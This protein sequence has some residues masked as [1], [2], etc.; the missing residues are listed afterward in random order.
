MYF[1]SISLAQIKENNFVPIADFAEV[2]WQIVD[3]PVKKYYTLS[4]KKRFHLGSV[5]E[6]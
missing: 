4:V 2:T 1:E 3:V 6:G 5:I